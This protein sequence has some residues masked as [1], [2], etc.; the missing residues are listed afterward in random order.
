MRIT[1]CNPYLFNLIINT[2]YIRYIVLLIT[3]ELVI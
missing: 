2:L 1:P 3:V